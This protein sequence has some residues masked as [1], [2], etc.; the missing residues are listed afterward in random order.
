MKGNAQRGCAS[1]LSPPFSFRKLR[2]HAFPRY[3]SGPLDLKFMD[4]FS[5][6]FLYRL[7]CKL[8][9]MTKKKGRLGLFSS[10]HIFHNKLHSP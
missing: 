7:A 5:I 4:D 10:Y 3:H 8:E 9:T 2:N 6:E 1:H